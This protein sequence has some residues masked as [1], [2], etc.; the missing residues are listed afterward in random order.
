MISSSDVSH[1]NEKFSASPWA[2]WQP[3]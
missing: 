2:V 1:P 3:G